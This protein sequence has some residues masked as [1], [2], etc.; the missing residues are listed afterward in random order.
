MTTVTELNTLEYTGDVRIDSLLDSVSPWNFL[1]P[2]RNT[3]YY[4][5][6]A[7]DGSYIDGESSTSLTAF[8]GSQQSATRSILG[9]VSA[10]TGI[11]FVEVASSSSA[12]LHFAATDLAGASTAGLTGISYA[13]SHASGKLIS[14]YA[15]ATI[16]LDNAEFGAYTNSPAA[17]SYGYET[18][19]HEIGHAMGL[20]H[21]F[22]T[23]NALPEKLDNT[24]N[25]V[26]SYTSAGDVKTDF[27][28]YD[29]LALTWIYGEDGLAGDWGYNSLYG[30]S[31]DPQSEDII[32]PYVLDFIP[33]DG[34]I[35]VGIDAQIE[36]T[37]N[38]NIARGSGSIRLKTSEGV[39]VEVF[40]ATESNRLDISGN[41]L[42]IT[43]SQPLSEGLEYLLELAPGTIQDLSGN[44][45]SGTDSYNF[46]TQ[47]PEDI[48]APQVENYS[49]ADGASNITLDTNIEINFDEPVARGVGS[50]TLRVQGGPTVTTWNI[51]DGAGEF[52]GDRTLLLSL[53]APLA[54]ETRYVLDL[55]E[56][57]VVDLSGNSFAGDSSYDFSTL[58][59]PD[60]IAPR[61]IDYSPSDGAS[62]VAVDS[63][64]LIVFDENI[65]LGE[66]TLR[67]EKAGGDSVQIWNISGGENLRVSGNTLS[68]SLDQFLEYGT[69]YNLRLPDGFV[70][71]LAG[72]EALG[73]TNYDFSTQTEPDTTPP[74]VVEFYPA[75]DS[76]NIDIGSTIQLVFNEPVSSGSGRLIL[77]TDSG[78]IVEVFD[79]SD[80]NSVEYSDNAVTLTPP[81][82]LEMATGYVL[83]IEEGAVVDRSGNPIAAVENYRFSTEDGPQN[84]EPQGNLLLYGDGILGSEL[85]AITRGISDD[86]GL[87]EFSY[88]WFRNGVEV[89]G[90]AF[91]SY[92]LTTDDNGQ[93]IDSVVSYTDGMG[94]TESVD[95]ESRL[96]TEATSAS[97]IDLIQMYVIILGRAPAQEGLNF[98]SSIINDGKNFEYVASEMWNSAG[99]REFYPEEMTT[100][101]I[102]TSVYTNIL[103]REPKPEGLAYWVGQWDSNGAVDTMLEMIG[104]LTANNSSNPLAIADKAL[105][106][107]KVDI[108]GY[109]AN[110]IGNTDVNLS[111]A[112]FDYLESGAGLLGTKLYVDSQMELIGQAQIIAGDDLLG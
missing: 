27:Q 66:G 19:L 6:D 40:D 90:E 32:N 101:E 4:T 26:M 38:E 103:V 82:Y 81:E 88:Q 91:E 63:D 70:E 20:G 21:P 31:L 75:N 93:V 110:T 106:Q 7:S 25:T 84:I 5:F 58:S 102:V 99:A 86:D 95:G 49:P 61:I 97:Y 17:G 10:I 33:A 65:L 59:A 87:G 36:L 72:N 53:N 23:P 76:S 46:F 35:D 28:E 13:Y 89:E 68:L 57:C 34:A 39:I 56:G 2:Y 98:W 62:S 9:D 15:D 37:F 12:D 64:I 79:P 24:N 43:P 30:F 41:I 8:N 85:M 100:E 92:L 83:V 45:F 78:S 112:A 108:G 96:I 60:E 77:Q 111:R 3:L 48:F 51:G 54:Y 80:S 44:P 74:E 11:N 16:W 104:A 22:N 69:T 29:L 42:L 94:N 50:I 71:D 18:L 105:F 1:L 107:A 55:G 67:L 73:A 109:L 47:E 14:L 52:L